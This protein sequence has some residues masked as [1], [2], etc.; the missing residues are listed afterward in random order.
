MPLTRTISDGKGIFVHIY[1][2][3]D[4]EKTSFVTPDDFN[5]QVGFAVNDEAKTYQPHIHTGLE[6]SIAGTAEFIFILQG[7][8]DVV[9]LD[10]QAEPRGEV[11]L[12]AQ[13]AFLQLRGGHAISTRPNTRFFELKQG[14]YS[15]HDI[16]KYAVDLPAT[17]S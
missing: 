14:P 7:V 12:T 2:L 4:L 10:E 3:A 5:F 11:S 8:M 6:R 15:G 16:D 1:D 9:F 13:M 17:E